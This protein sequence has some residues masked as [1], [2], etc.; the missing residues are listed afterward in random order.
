MTAEQTVQ[1]PMLYVR[2]LLAHAQHRHVKQMFL[3][4]RTG[5]L[6]SFTLKRR[7]MAIAS[8]AGSFRLLEL[9]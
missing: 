9:A 1:W 6:L 5:V 7:G 3:M 2:A 8:E 4:S